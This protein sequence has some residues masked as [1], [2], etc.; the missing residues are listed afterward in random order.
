MML[1]GSDANVSLEIG[2]KLG[3]AVWVVI[4]HY[5]DLVFSTAGQARADTATTCKQASMH[6]IRAHLDWHDR[7]TRKTGEETSAHS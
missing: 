2:R 3:K 1:S 4:W 7:S 6:K 5:S